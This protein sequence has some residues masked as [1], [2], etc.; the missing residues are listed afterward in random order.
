MENIEGL[1]LLKDIRNINST[2]MGSNLLM[3]TNATNI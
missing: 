2:P 1:Y 3:V